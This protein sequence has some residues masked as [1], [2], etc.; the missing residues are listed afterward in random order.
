VGVKCIEHGHLMDD[1][2]ARLMA[3]RDI[4]LSIQPFPA[5]IA[6]VFPPGSD[7]Q[8]TARGRRRRW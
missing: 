1:A 2:T 8:A 7:E 3:E 5:E 6:D 4:W